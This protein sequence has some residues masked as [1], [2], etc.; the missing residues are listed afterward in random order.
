MLFLDVGQDLNMTTIAIRSTIMPARA[1]I[2]ES[3]SGFGRPVPTKLAW[4]NNNGIP[5]AQRMPIPKMIPS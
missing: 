3:M 2:A 4:G 5:A 1:M